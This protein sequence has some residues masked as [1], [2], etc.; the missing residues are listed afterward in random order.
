MPREDE[1]DFI[2]SG[3]E[4]CKPGKSCGPSVRNFFLFHYIIEGKGIYVI[5][6]TEYKVKCGQMFLICPG[7]LAFYKADETDP[8]IYSWIGFTGEGASLF[9]DLLG[10]SKHYPVLDIP[11]GTG[12]GNI[13]KELSQLPLFGH[14]ERY[15]SISLMYKLFSK[16]LCVLSKPQ[17]SSISYMA[18]EYVTTVMSYIHTHYQNNISVSEIAKMIGIDRTYLYTLF[19]NITGKSIQKYLIDH[20]LEK[21][22]SL[23]ITSKLTVLQT[24]LSVGYSDQCNFSKAIKKKYGVSP[25]MLRQTHIDDSVI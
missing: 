4:E 19:K 15:Y 21:A 13:L 17:E 12:I 8:W 25:E 14:S 11:P 3:Y 18:N 10:L 5:N 24:A 1:L 16:L 20:R 22:A 9:I 7:D 2:T 23:L 6:K